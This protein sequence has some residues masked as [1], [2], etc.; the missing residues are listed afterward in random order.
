MLARLEEVFTDALTALRTPDVDLE[1]LRYQTRQVDLA[2]TALCDE[3][4]AHTAH[5]ID[6]L[7]RRAHRAAL[8]LMSSLEDLESDDR[9]TSDKLD[10]AR[11]TVEELVGTLGSMIDRRVFE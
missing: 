8:D 5:T 4:E 7:V 3:A 1:H 10:L 2:V 11:G 6:D 9:R